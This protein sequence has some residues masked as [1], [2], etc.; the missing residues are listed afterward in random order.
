VERTAVLKKIAFVV[1]AT[2]TS[3]LLAGETPRSLKE[4]FVL[5]WQQQA[6]IRGDPGGGWGGRGPAG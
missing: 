5:H 6:T 2:Y 1:V 3:L 4:R